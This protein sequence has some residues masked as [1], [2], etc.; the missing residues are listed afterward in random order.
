[1]K[2]RN[3]LIMR[4]IVA[5]LAIA[6]LGVALACAGEDATPEPTSPA[7]DGHVARND[8]RRTAYG[9]TGGAGGHGCS[10]DGKISAESR[11]MIRR[12]DSPL[13]AGRTYSGPNGT[14][15]RST[16]TI[17]AAVTLTGVSADFRGAPCYGL[18]PG[19]GTS[20]R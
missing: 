8:G 17:R 7:A 5:I 11:A 4:P 20:R 3:K 13:K 10:L 19:R 14:A 6:M 16:P 9:D 15:R 2:L 12:G 18:T 1:M